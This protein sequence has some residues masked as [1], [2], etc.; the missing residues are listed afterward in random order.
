[1]TAASDPLVLRTLFIPYGH[2]R[3]LHE[4]RVKAAGIRF[5][6]VQ[7]VHGRPPFQWMVPEPQLD[8]AEM[9]I[10][11][12]LTTRQFNKPYTALPIFVRRNFHH[13]HI[14]YDPRS[15]IRTPKDLEGRRVGV[16]RTPTSSWGLWTRGILA[17][18]HGV[19]IGRI[20]WV[21]ED[22]DHWDEFRP[23]SNVLVQPGADL[24]QM[25]LAGEIAA[26]VTPTGID[27]PDVKELL[28]EPDGDW[29]RRTGLYPIDHLLVV[30][31]PVL[32]AHPWVAAALFSAFTASKG[33][34]LSDLQKNGPASPEDAAVLQAQQIVGGDPFPHG[35]AP[36]RMAL[37][38]AVRFAHLSRLIP[39]QYAIEELFAS[40]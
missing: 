22:H 28:P 25:L 15:G 37:E 33:S 40:G 23:P 7:M 2:A 9:P 3:A 8:L 13:R 26:A 12:Y 32:A 24:K 16:A 36:N 20:T 10:G 5:D 6:H 34:Y 21:T 35:I 39:R 38:T 1:M 30:R 31:D 14:F 4:G 29:Y 17:E 27:S 19:D 11:A 18:Q